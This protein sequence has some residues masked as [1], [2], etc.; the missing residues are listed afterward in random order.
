MSGRQDLNLRP[1]LSKRCNLTRL[2]YSQNTLVKYPVTRLR[3]QYYPAAA[4]FLLSKMFNA[5]TNQ[6]LRRMI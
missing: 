5:A 4:G 2:I 1:H 6:S 3:V